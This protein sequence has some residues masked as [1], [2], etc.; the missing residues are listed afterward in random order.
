MPTEFNES[1]FDKPIIFVSLTIAHVT[2][3]SRALLSVRL[4][5]KTASSI[6][7]RARLEQP[8]L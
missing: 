4:V 3:P 7:I 2:V 8:I 1:D 5:Q 6:P